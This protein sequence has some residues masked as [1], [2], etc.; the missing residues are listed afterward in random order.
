[1]ALTFNDSVY[2]TAL[3]T[4]TT[5]DA[6]RHVDIISCRPATPIFSFFRLDGDGTG[7]TYCFAELASNTPLLPGWISPESMFASEA[8]RYWTLLKW[9]EDCVW[10]PEELLDDDVHASHHF[11]EEKIFAGFV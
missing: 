2:R 8:W 9:V 4:E 3:L 6:F 10:W 7:R 11:R 1:M 5:I